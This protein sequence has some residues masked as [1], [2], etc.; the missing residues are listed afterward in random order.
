M[1]NIV[2]VVVVVVVV[3]IVNYQKRISNFQLELDRYR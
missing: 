2:V 3:E 1:G